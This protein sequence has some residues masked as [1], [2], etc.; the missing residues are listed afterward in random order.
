MDNFLRSFRRSLT[1]IHGLDLKGIATS[2]NALVGA[3]L[4]LAVIFL[5][6][7]NRLI[8]TVSK[9]PL[10]KN[11][12][13][14]KF[15]SESKES[16]DYFKRSCGVPELLNKKAL[17]YVNTQQFSALRAF[18]KKGITFE[19]LY[20]VLK[21]GLENLENVSLERRRDEKVPSLGCIISSNNIALNPALLDSK[22]K[23]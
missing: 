20:S 6:S 18:S 8:S 17:K 4:I 1:K 16:M 5:A 10:D 7:I 22:Q 3:I 2:K 23:F 19:S 11:I 15:I 21:F 14:S 12:S 9:K 13:G